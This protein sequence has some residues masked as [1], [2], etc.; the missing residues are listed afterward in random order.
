ML[1]NSELSYKNFKNLTISLRI[2]LRINFN[3]LFSYRAELN[4]R[5]PN[6]MNRCPQMHLWEN[7]STVI[8][9]VGQLQVTFMYEQLYLKP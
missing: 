8:A 2:P 5:I 4:K 6:N 7:T 3:T 1:L 9:V